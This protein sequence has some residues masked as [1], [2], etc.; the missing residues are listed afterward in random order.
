MYK[1]ILI[2]GGIVRIRTD[3]KANYRAIFFDGKTIR[4]K[5]NTAL[6]ISSPKFSEIEDVSI[7]NKCFGNCPYCYCSTESSGKNFEN[8]VVKAHDVWGMRDLNDRPFQIAIGGSGEPTLHPDFPEFVITAKALGIMPN[9]TTNGMHITPTILAATEKYCGGV[10]VSFHPHLETYFHKAI[11]ELRELKT[12]LNAHIVIGDDLSLVNLQRIFN[13][14]ADAIKYFVLLP[15]QAVGRAR[16]IETRKTWDSLFAWILSLD[17][18][19]REKFAYGAN[20][21]GYIQETKP[22]LD[23]DIYEPEMY[24]GYRIMDDSY[25]RLRYSSYNTTFKK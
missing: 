20:F 11:G 6:P 22:P 18:A 15:Y 10:A 23:I 3:A 1:G 12:Q 8:I 4:Q 7:N 16:E 19:C 14:Y 17:D 5:I 25:K 2:G 9:Y 13:Q 21:Y 24:S